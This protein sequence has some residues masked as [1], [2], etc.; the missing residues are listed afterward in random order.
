M[1][2]THIG[3][4][5][6]GESMSKSLNFA[7]YI[8]LDGTSPTQELRSKTRMLSFQNER[9]LS[10]FPVWSFDGS[11]TGQAKIDNSDLILKPVFF[12]KDPIR[13]AGDYIVLCEVINNDD[14][15]PHATNKRA[16]LREVLGKVPDLEPY[17]GFE[18]EY[19]LLK[20]TD[21][22]NQVRGDNKWP[23]D[24]PQESYPEPQGPY[25]CSVGAGKAI[26]R[27]IIEEHSIACMEAG[28]NIYGTNAEVMPSQ[29][30]FQIGYRG[31]QNEASDPVT[32]SDH[33]W[34][35]RYL[36]NRIAEKHGVSISFENKPIPGDWN[37]AGLH[38]NFSTKTTR[39]KKSG[40]AAIEKLIGDLQKHHAEHIKQYGHG[41][42]DRLTGQHETCH[43]DQFKS[44]VSHRGVSIRIP[45]STHRNEC[46]Y[47]E[48]RRPGA[49]ADPYVISHALL[50]T[51]CS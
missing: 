35:A 25:Y 42:A 20:Q 22:K 26:G 38:T 45:V 39:D 5:N 21:K 31:I 14:I 1:L 34:V 40:K 37:G 36:I 23:L 2:Q 24:W 7:E 15:T 50:T 16:V 29:W 44:G 11:S 41:L 4:Q 6:Y 18:Q 13:G 10:S 33:L 51:A 9:D 30:E 28:I 17:I 19:T 43:I 3:K 8:W 49:N 46:G 27:E 32:M 48:D 12:V 47:I